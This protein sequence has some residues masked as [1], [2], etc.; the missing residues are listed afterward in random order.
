MVFFLLLDPIGS[1]DTRNIGIDSSPT[2]TTQNCSSFS[3]HRSLRSPV[4]ASSSPLLPTQRTEH[5]VLW[6]RGV[7]EE[8]EDSTLELLPAQSYEVAASRRA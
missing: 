6:E 4:Y 1:L 7:L 2:S 8:A 5:I 3:D